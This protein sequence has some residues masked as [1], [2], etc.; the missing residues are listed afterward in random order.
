[1][2]SLLQPCRHPSDTSDPPRISDGLGVSRPAASRHRQGPLPVLA[3]LHARG[4]TQGGRPLRLTFEGGLAPGG[5]LSNRFCDAVKRFRGDGNPLCDNE[6]RLATA[7]S[8]S[9][10]SRRPAAATSSS[11]SCGGWR[12]ILDM[13]TARAIPSPD[14]GRLPRRWRSG[15]GLGASLSDDRSHALAVA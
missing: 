2:A 15:R 9:G 6:K 7:I 10:V 5:E 4:K 11:A 13:E 3:K 8:G 1:M 12:G 14:R